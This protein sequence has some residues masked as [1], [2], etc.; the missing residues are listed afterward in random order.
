ME[1]L[2]LFAGSCSFSKV[3]K[4]RGHHAFTTDIEQFGDIDYVG[5]ILEMTANDFPIEP[6][7]IWASPPCYAF[8]ISSV[9]HHFHKYEMPDGSIYHEPKSETADKGVRMVQKTIELV[10]NLQPTYYFME[11]PRGLLR[12]LRLVEN[13]PDH[14]T[15]TYC[16]YG[17]ERMKPTDIWHNCHKWEPRPMCKNGD[18]CHTSAP[19]GSRTG[20]QGRKNSFERSRV[21]SEL[22]NEILE[23]CEN[24]VDNL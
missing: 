1:I 7:I 4:K 23:V 14:A 2:E 21:P 12:K 24:E 22:C 19:R 9:R 5:D 3:A 17:E 16:Q 11:N 13:F 18:N 15:V 20:T 6:D 8:S 10:N